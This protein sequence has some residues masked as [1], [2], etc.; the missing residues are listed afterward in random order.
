MTASHCHTKG[1]SAPSAFN[2]A[3]ELNLLCVR[4]QQKRTGIIIVFNAATD[5]LKARVELVSFLF[6]FTIMFP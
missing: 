4:V 1:N 3:P 6:S 2:W 5:D